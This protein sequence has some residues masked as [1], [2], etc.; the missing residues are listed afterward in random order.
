MPRRYAALAACL[1]TLAVIVGCSRD[2]TTES[3]SPSTEPPTAEQAPPPT[4]LS[5]EELAPV[6]REVAASGAGPTKIVIELAKPVIEEAQVGQALSDTE[7][8]IEPPVEG[9]LR[10]TSPSTLTFQ[11]AKGFR[12]STR[13]EV[14]LTSL[15]TPAGVLTSPDAGR[16]VRIFTTPA[17]DFARFE[18]TS[19]DYPRKRAEAQLIFSGAVDPQ[20][21]ERKAIVSVIG[22][23]GR[24]RRD[25]S[26]R[27]RPGREPHIVLAQL[28]SKSLQ[29][30][31]RIDLKLAEGVPS[32]LDNSQ[33]AGR[34]TASAELSVGP[35]A[36]VLA[37]YRAEGASGFYVQVICNDTSLGSKRYYWDRTLQEYY[38]VST[39]CQPSEADAAFG[40]HFDPPVDHTVTPAGGGFRIFG[41]FERG[42][43]HMRIE[44][45]VRTADGG[46][47]HEAYSTDFTVP[48]RSPSLRFVSKGRY[49]PRTAWTSLPL[50]HLNVSGATLSV[51]H[52]P[53]EN[54]VFWMGDDDNE[55]A[56]ERTSNLIVRNQIALGGDT[57]VETTTYVDL[58]S[59]VP[60][61][62]R[63]LIE[64]KV[65]AGAASDT[66]R[67]LLTDL[68]LVAKRF[69]PQNRPTVRAWAL[70]METLEPV[71]G[72]DI[73]LIRK[74][75]Y[76]MANCR[77]G[78]DGG[79][80]LTSAEDEVDPAAPFALLAA[81]DGELTY[82][83]F[84]ELE[85]EVQEARIGGAPYGDDA[86][87][88]RASLYS[89]RGVYRP[90]ET[91]HLAAI[92]RQNDH[93]APPAGMPVI[94][95]LTDPRGKTIKRTALATND[96][97][98]VSLDVDFPAFATT[99]R[100]EAR[101][102]VAD[103]SIGQYRFQV[104]EFVP[105]RMKV[106]VASAEPE[107]LFG[108]EMAVAVS[109]RYLFGGV[110]AKHKVEVSCEIAP[111]N[112]LPAANGNFHY[113]VWRPE[114]SPVRPLALG[115]V[116][117]ELDDAGAGTFSCPGAG[118]GGGF[119]GPAE[120]IARAAV[121]ESGSG[122]TTVN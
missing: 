90:G 48:A 31:G 77:T 87:K 91:A 39:R 85:A 96:A 79:C 115:S 55:A 11:P 21:V 53:A 57:D 29:G 37:S 35:R 56:S 118:R 22:A 25:A 61:D 51:R 32:A 72:A 116:T 26:V 3:P 62:T 70:D 86:G 120:L 28:A 104:E 7:I 19:I 68:H 44:S 40:I 84:S 1:L 114:N 24:A 117:A 110:P 89:D 2:S 98:F 122:R 74:S 97:G 63:G 12:P 47:F 121:F 71:S 65:Q 20:Q 94:A 43:Y 111:S 15:E 41:D 45:G 101:L 67:L 46:M 4:Q 106:E 103:K 27:Y 119:S 64:L 69:G 18:L 93:L 73:R 50:R 60:A 99:G 52:V 82:L 76:T 42:S 59:W 13:Y 36:Q 80:D 78:R 109:S 102:E 16:W 33:L 75:G 23:D 6:I 66:A 105:E 112:F 30:G 83:K 88:Y 92:V 14:E 108:Q 5:P 10:F 34:G 38:Q 113:G 54:L 8:R 49:L 100:Y 17:F 9:E 95:K 81:A 58:A 107:Y